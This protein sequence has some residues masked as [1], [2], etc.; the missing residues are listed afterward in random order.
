MTPYP[1][2]GRSP[3]GYG[4]LI[5]SSCVLSGLTLRNSRS[6]TRS[7]PKWARDFGCLHRVRQLPLILYSWWLKSVGYIPHVTNPFWDE[8]SSSSSPSIMCTPTRRVRRN[9][10]HINVDP[11]I[12]S[13]AKW[14]GAT[15]A[16]WSSS[17]G[18]WQEGSR[19][20]HELHGT[21]IYPPFRSI[22]VV[23]LSNARLRP[24]KRIEMWH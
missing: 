1:C 24:E 23:T 22:I 6:E 8:C 17:P 19:P 11:E 5:K 20:N 7:K 16:T 2:C 9:H 13:T 21:S 18:P 3:D 10:H 15:S 12:Q 4:P 14:R